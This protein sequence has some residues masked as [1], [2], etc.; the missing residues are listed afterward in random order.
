MGNLQI[1][2]GWDDDPH[3]KLIETAAVE[4]AGMGV[5]TDD[6]LNEIKETV[7]DKLSGK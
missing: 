3:L 6:E 4:L 2:P 1:N 5:I 7:R